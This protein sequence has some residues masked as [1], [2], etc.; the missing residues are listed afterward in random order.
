METPTQR[1]QGSSY[2]TLEA[3]PVRLEKD[4]LTTLDRRIAAA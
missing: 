1:E 3:A 4:S 2:N